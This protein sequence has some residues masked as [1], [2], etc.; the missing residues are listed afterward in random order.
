MLLTS[1]RTVAETDSDLYLMFNDCQQFQPGI[2]DQ[3]TSHAPGSQ[4]HPRVTATV[5][6]KSCSEARSA[7]IVLLFG[8]AF[9]T[10][11]STNLLAGCKALRTYTEEQRG[12]ERRGPGE[13][14]D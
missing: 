6:P 5:W 1:G 4:P 12:V 11:R 7:Y 3:T 14:G 9:P 8:T 2:W 13:L 10:L